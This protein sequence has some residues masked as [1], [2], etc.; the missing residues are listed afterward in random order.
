MRQGNSEYEKRLPVNAGTYDVT[1]SRPADNIYNKFEYTYMAVITVDKAVR[2]IGEVKLEAEDVGYTFL[3][4]KLIGDGE[5]DDLSSEAKFTYE[6]KNSGSVI[7]RSADRD[8]YIYD[9]LPNKTYD[10]TVKVTDDPNY[11]DAESEVGAQVSTLS[12]PKDSWVDKGNY[13]TGWYDNNKSSAYFTINSAKQLAGLSYL[14]NNGVTFENKT[15]TLTAD[16]DLRGHMWL[17]I[18]YND[19]CWFRG[20]FDGGNHKITGLYYSNSGAWNPGL[21]GKVKNSNRIEIKNILLDHSYIYG[22]SRVGGIVGYAQDA[23]TINNCV[24][25]ARIYSNDSRVGGILGMSASSATNVMNCVNYGYIR[26]YNEETG[27]IVG[28]VD[29][30]TVMNCANYGKVYGYNDVGGIVGQ[31]ATKNAKAYNNFNVGTVT[32]THYYIGAVVGRNEEDRGQVHQVYYLRYSA[33][34][35]GD[36]RK[37]VGGEKSYVEDDRSKGGGIKAAYFTSPTSAL[38]R[39]C[40]DD[41]NINQGLLPA[42]NHWAARCSDSGA[43]QW[44]STGRGGYPLPKGSPVPEAMDT[45]TLIR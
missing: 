12:A 4:L 1:I 16:V 33:N 40:E 31:N 30:G 7:G 34:C 10:I 32:G 35:N 19:N 41:T 45:R 13:D 23:V 8:S 17:P 36:V 29:T 25:Y 9:I 21:F 26:G 6:A 42:L 24:N 5:I 14:V 3:K 18:G 11:L 28:Y 22:Y 15:I 43:V 27:G 37:A 20:T 44:E 2:T 39:R 38:S